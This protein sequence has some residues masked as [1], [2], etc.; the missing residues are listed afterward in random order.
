MSFCEAL[1]LQYP[2]IQAPMAGVSTPEMAAAVTDAGALGSISVGASTPEQAATMIAKTRALTKGPINVNVFCHAFVKRDAEREKAWIARFRTLFARYNTDLPQQ[3]QEIYQTFLGNEPMLDVIEHAK[4]AAVSFH[5]GLPAPEVIQRL[6]QRGIV[7]LATATSVDEARAIAE[8]GIDFIVAQG[9]EAGGHRGHFDPTAFDHQMS[10]FTLVQAIRQRLTHPVIVAGGIMDGAGIA[11][12]LQLGATG[13]Q[14]GTAFVLCPESSANHAYRAALKQ[15]DAHATVM[16][17]AISGR[18]ARCLRNAF[19]A[20]SRDFSTESIPDYPLTYSLG[21]ALA[22]A[23]AASNEHGFGAQWAGQGAAL[24]REM[25][26]GDLVKT[27]VDEW[28]KASF[29][30]VLRIF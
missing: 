14:L 11:A 19:C 8:S 4:P 26:A 3:L 1:R 5:F 30:P 9:I 6:K 21:K 29:N 13:V 18:Q 25:P 27:L 15:A 10:T 20:F 23:A 24:A 16:T 28:Q 17:A 2:I 7:T 12:M 22:S